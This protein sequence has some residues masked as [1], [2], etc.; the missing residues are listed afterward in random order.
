MSAGGSATGHLYSDIR[1]RHIFPELLGN[2]VN[3]DLRGGQRIGC[4]AGFNNER[5]TVL[6]HGVHHLTREDAGSY[7]GARHDGDRHHGALALVFKYVLK[8]FG[9]HRHRRHSLAGIVR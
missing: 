7:L 5:R 8:L 2:G 3:V 1:Q 6:L 9:I 4:A